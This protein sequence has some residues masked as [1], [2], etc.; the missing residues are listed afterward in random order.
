MDEVMSIIDSNHNMSSWLCYPVSLQIGR[1]L[2]ASLFFF[3]LSC[4]S[5]TQTPDDE[6]L[7]KAVRLMDRKEETE[8]KVILDDLIRRNPKYDQAMIYR[9]KIAWENEDFPMAK[10]LLSRI[11]DRSKKLLGMARFLE[12]EIAIASGR[13]RLAEQKWRESI[14]LNPLYALT[15]QRLLDLLILQY[16][17]EDAKPSQEMLLRIRPLELQECLRWQRVLLNRAN[18]SDSEAQLKKFIDTDPSDLDSRAALARCLISLERYGEAV[19]V[20]NSEVKHSNTIGRAS[21]LWACAQWD[22]GE[23]QPVLDNL[24]RKWPLGSSDPWL[25]RAYARI[26]LDGEDWSGCAWCCWQ[27]LKIWPEDREACYRLAQ[28]LA[29]LDLTSDADHW[30][31][32]TQKLD[33]LAARVQKISISAQSTREIQSRLVQEAVKSLVELKRPEQAAVWLA[34][35]ISWSPQDRDLQRQYM[36]LSQSKM[37]SEREVTLRSLDERLSA[38][39]PEFPSFDRIQIRNVKGSAGQRETEIPI[40]LEDV[41]TEAGL[42]FQFFNGRTGFKYILESIGAGVSV[43]DYDAD[44]WPDLY[45]PQGCRIPWQP[46]S[47]EHLDQLYRNCG[48]GRFEC[49]TTAAGVME[50]RYSQ[51]SAAGDFNNDGF[52]DVFVCNFGENTLWQNNGD[53]TFS[54]IANKAGFRGD[55]WSSSAAWGDLDNDSDLDL[56]V[57]KYVQDPFKVCTTPAGEYASCPPSSFPGSFN[58]FYLNVGDGTF[59]ER[60]DDAGLT[61]PRGKGLGTVIADLDNDGRMDIYVANDTTPNFLFRNMGNSASGLPQFTEIG[62]L[63]GAALSRDGRAQ[64]GMGIACAD[65]DNDGMLDLYVTNFFDDYNT[66]YL[67]QGMMSFADRTSQAG[68]V[69]PTLK[70]LGFGTQAIDFDLDRKPDLIVANGH[71]DEYSDAGVLWKMPAQVFANSGSGKFRDVSEDCGEYFRTKVFGRGLARL[72]F[73]RDGRPDAIIVHL[74]R[75]VALLENQTSTRHPAVSIRL[76]GTDS[77]REAIGAAIIATFPDGSFRHQICGGDGYFSTNDRRLLIGTGQFEQISELTIEWPSGKTTRI[78]VV[79]SGES[80]TVI[81]SRGRLTD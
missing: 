26:A 56:Y 29:H 5:T 19:E 60:L 52:C 73:N 35:L 38:M 46:T 75:T 17:F 64:A 68:L 41:G 80:L 11:G 34:L 4:G 63:S 6:L 32:E 25:W 37:I 79:A 2:I 74:D 33:E 43:I 51:G 22:R 72:D 81:E 57:V 48:G 53:G 45:F 15:H 28:S 76:I 70:M 65:F 67:N 7:S 27:I 8:A 36:E 24:P 66:L 21:G 14:Q 10:D 49:V 20:L 47:T 58:Q 23:R 69:A 78:H 50:N 39:R 18:F 55:D 16:R 12:G 59:E 54:E 13:A 77:N 1:C 3:V 44:G 40:R 62:L 31:F 9:A 42:L 71:I 61:A 30:Y